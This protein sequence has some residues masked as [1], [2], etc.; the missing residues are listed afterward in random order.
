MCAIIATSW[1]KKVGSYDTKFKKK[2]VIIGG[3][4]GTS[5]VLTGLKVVL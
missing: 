4:T 2:I 3:G 1:V 5:S